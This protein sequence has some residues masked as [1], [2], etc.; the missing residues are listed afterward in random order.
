MKCLEDFHTDAVWD[1]SENCYFSELL[2]GKTIVFDDDA[3][4]SEPFVQ[5]RDQVAQFNK[6][7]DIKKSPGLRSSLQAVKKLKKAVGPNIPVIG[8]VPMPFRFAAEVRGMQNIL[9]D[10]A[11]DP[12]LVRALEEYYIPI[13]TECAEAL[14]EAG[15]DLVM[16]MNPLANR[17]CISRKH[18]EE[19]VHP[20]CRLLLQQLKE[21]GIKSI[22]HVCGDWSDRMDLLVDEG[23]ECLWVDKADLEPLKRTIGAKVCIMGNVPVTEVLLQ[24]T[25]EDVV[26]ETTRCLQA[27]APGGGYILSG[28]CLLPR[29]APPENVLAMEATCRKLGKYPL[30]N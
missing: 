19:L 13:G 23:A 18:F 22:F 12:D 28:S 10:I 30:R 4:A 26:R 11:M 29:D 20:Y 25:P 14:I 21:R 6:K 24:G 1:L 7:P 9:L 15:A 27:G 5:S 3:P 17:S 8:T 16:Q 2:G